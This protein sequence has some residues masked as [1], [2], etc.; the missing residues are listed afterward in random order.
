MIEDLTTDLEQTLSHL[1]EAV[2]RARLEKRLTVDELAKNSRVS[3]LTVYR[4]EAGNGGVG[5]RNLMAVLRALDLDPMMRLVDT[6]PADELPLHPIHVTDDSV[7]AVIEDAVRGA[8]QRLD[9]LFQQ[10][11]PEVDGISSNFQGLL[12][13]H[14]T[15]ML[16]GR[17]AANLSRQVCLKGLLYSDDLLGREYSLADDANGFLVR[18][19]GTDKVLDNNR[20]V[21]ARRAT[22]LYSSWDAAAE[23][24]KHYLTTNGHP[25][26]PLRIVSG[27]FAPEESGGVRFTNPATR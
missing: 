7:R 10:A 6:L 11:K 26:G 17:Q 16:C 1:G 2:A 19:V 24:V 9:G 18:M 27:W 12:V 5:T 23:S 3:A 4:I 21:R 25:P 15:A 20:F 13:D 14:V 22:D 8:C